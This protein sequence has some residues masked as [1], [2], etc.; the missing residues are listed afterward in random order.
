[1]A[2][3]FVLETLAGWGDEA[4]MDCASLLVSELV[5]NAIVHARSAVELELSR[6]ADADVLRVAVRDASV[7]PPRMG[8]FDLEALSGRGL[9]LVEALSDRWGVEADASGKLVWFELTSHLG[10]HLQSRQTA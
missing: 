8:G 9:A 7:R 3:R 6:D 1:M 10:S 5:T 2:R 4:S